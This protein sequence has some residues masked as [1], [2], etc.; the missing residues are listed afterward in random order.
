MV[1]ARTF[2]NDPGIA[3]QRDQIL[4]KFTQV[5]GCVGNVKRLTDHSAARLQDCYGTLPL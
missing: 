4:S 5:L 3:L 1:S 2:H